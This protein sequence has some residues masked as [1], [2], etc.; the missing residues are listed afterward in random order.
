MRGRR[1]TRGGEE[2]APQRA[3]RLCPRRQL[4]CR[5]C[6]RLRATAPIMGAASSLHHATPNVQSGAR[7]MQI[8][9]R[10][11]TAGKSPYEK[12]PF[13]R[14]TSEIKN[15]DGSVVFKLREL[16][17]PRALEPGGR[18]H[19]RPE[20]FPQGRRAGAPQA[21]RGDAGP[22]LAVALGRRRAARS[23]SGPSSDRSRRRDRR[24]PGV[25]PP[26]RHLDLLGL[27]GR[28]LH[29]R[30]RRARLL[31]RAP[32]H[33]G[34]AVSARPTARSGSTPA[35]TGPTASTARARATTTSI[36]RRAS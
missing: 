7:T 6:V 28:L 2:V 25:R 18:R 22:V 23:P 16:R 12:I 10:F 3:V 13:R 34:H 11:T 26:R 14:A 21:H 5:A 8:K 9:R 33:A 20:V 32:L 31:R 15:P 4:W 30:G 17:G 27:E 36:T 35:C 24:P 19:P 29:Q 1:C